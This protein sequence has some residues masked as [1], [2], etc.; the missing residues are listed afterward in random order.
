MSIHATNVASTDKESTTCSLL[1]W[2]LHGL[3]GLH[4]DG[5]KI[6]H[7]ARLWSALVSIV[8]A[9]HSCAAI[10]CTKGRHWPKRKHARAVESTVH[11]TLWHSS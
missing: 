8:E 9:S 4:Y 10:H 3:H 5:E 7:V 6:L 1:V 11:A 2:R